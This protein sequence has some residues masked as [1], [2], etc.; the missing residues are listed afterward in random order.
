MS[1][2]TYRSFGKINLY[3]DVLD[4]RPDGFTNIET[5]LQSINLW[6]SLDVEPA[7]AD[8]ALTCSNPTLGGGPD[9]LVYRAAKLFQERTKIE[10][11][12]TI[13]LQKNLPIAAGLAGGSGN[14]AAALIALN[15]LWEIGWNKSKLC[16]LALELGSDVPFCLLGGTVAAT[17]RGEE[18]EVLSPMEPRWLVLVHPPL[19]VSAGYAYGHPKLERNTNAR[20]EGLTPQFRRALRTLESRKPEDMIFNRMETGIF[21][22]HPEL[23]IIKERLTE[24]GCM[25]SAMSGSG[26]TVF[27]LCDGEADAR[28]VAERIDDYPTTVVRTGSQGVLRE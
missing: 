8:I 7:P 24:F 4:R 16:E 18:M 21:S 3:L 22:D 5:V 6:D 25:A 9:N 23:A 26:P 17:G 12:A 27:G 20:K 15:D 2:F 13:H 14:A 19:E 10:A 1:S 28:A 11:G